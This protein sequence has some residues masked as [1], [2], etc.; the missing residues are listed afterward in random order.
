[1]IVFLAE[2]GKRVIIIADIERGAGIF[3]DPVQVLSDR[4]C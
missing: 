4:H 2:T 1:M 3:K